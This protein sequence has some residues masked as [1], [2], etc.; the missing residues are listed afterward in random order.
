LLFFRLRWCVL[1]F[2]SCWLGAAPNARAA[3]S[4]ERLSLVWD[5]PSECPDQARVIA[6]LER[7]VRRDG[8]SGPRLRASAHVE[9]LDDGGW[10]LRLETVS[11]T[12]RDERELLGGSCQALVDALAVMLALQLN[13]SEP[14][15]DAPSREAPAEKAAPPPASAT[16]GTA[17]ESEA[18]RSAAPTTENAHFQLAM[19]G[20]LDATALPRIAIGAR[21]ELTWNLRRWYVSAGAGLW[22]SQQQAIAP[23]HSGHASFGFRTL[24]LGGCHATWGQPVRLGPCLAAEVGQ[25]SA[26]SSGVRAPGQ[27]DQPWLAALGGVGFWLPLGESARLTSSLWVVVPLRRPSFVIEGVGAIHQ[28]RPA[29]GRVALGLAWRF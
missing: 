5:A 19:A 22:L 25:L 7:L 27:V 14:T 24:S 23:G 2:A 9:K 29:G 28:P 18:V 13:P 17:V 1:A 26:E 4:I 20:S 6:Q 10:T 3:S 16:P 12:T 8:A 21:V 11:D 15:P